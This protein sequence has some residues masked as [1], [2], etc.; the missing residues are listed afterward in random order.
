VRYFV[1]GPAII[2]SACQKEGHMKRNC[3][4]SE[5]PPLPAMPRPDKQHVRMLND[6]LPWVPG[7]YLAA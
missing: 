4:D 3:P 7:W 6:F 5:L 1:Q 2:C